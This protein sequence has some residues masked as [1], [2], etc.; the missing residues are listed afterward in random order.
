MS[1]F[2]VTKPMIWLF[3]KENSF[4][5]VVFFQLKASNISHEIPYLELLSLYVVQWI[6]LVKGQNS[7]F[8]ELNY[9]DIW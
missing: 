5:V 2:F 1:M 8:C 6:F 9:I 7:V 3:A 4:M